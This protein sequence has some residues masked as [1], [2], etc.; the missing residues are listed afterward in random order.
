MKMS[1]VFNLPLKAVEPV[2]ATNGAW[3]VVS[4]SVEGESVCGHIGKFEIKKGPH[5]GTSKYLSIELAENMA[6]S[7]VY[8]INNHDRLEQENKQLIEALEQLVASSEG[9]EKQLNDL[10]MCSDYGESEELCKAKQLLNKQ[11]GDL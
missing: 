1:E 7:A 5:S 8:A 11:A 9:N 4:A 3:P 2:I 10:L 6:K